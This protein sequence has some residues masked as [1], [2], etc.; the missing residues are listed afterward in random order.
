MTGVGEP[1]ERSIAGQYEAACRS[2]AA[3][4]AEEGGEPTDLVSLIVYT[5]DMGAY[6]ESLGPIGEAH[7]R[8]LGNHYPPI[9]LIGVATLFEPDALVELVGTAVVPD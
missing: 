7:R 1:P 9:A 4:I 6:R 2:M 3:V 8:V 5:T